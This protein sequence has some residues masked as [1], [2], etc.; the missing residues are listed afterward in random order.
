MTPAPAGS[1]G[2][3]EGGGPAAP[4]SIAEVAALL[5]RLRALSEAGH[6]VDPRERAAFL[7]DKAALLAR[8]N[9]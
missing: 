1:T 2:A 6:P 5:R 9:P 7:A 3:Q 8:I 4:P